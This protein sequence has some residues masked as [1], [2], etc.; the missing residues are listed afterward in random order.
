MLEIVQFGIAPTGLEQHRERAVL[1]GRDLANRVHDHA[2][3]EAPICHLE[4]FLR[5]TVSGL[6][7]RP[8]FG[9][10][11]PVFTRFLGRERGVVA[12]LM[13]IW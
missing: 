8:R 3:F 13:S 2:D 10:Q 12:A 5:E 7:Y 1:F 11:A 6:L 4:Q 9:R